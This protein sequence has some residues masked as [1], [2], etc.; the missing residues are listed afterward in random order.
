MSLDSLMLSPSLKASLNEAA[1]RY[2]RDVAGAA[3]YLAGRGLDEAAAR[4]HHLGFVAEPVVGHERFEGMLAIPYMTPL[5]CVAM[6]FRRIDGEDPKYDSPSGQKA[7]LY[8][9]QTLGEGGPVALICEGELDAVAAEAHLG[10]PA[11]GSPGTTWLDHWSRC[12]G[13]FDRVVVVAD[14]D[15][16]DDGSDPGLKHAQKVR[17]SIEGADLVTPPAGLDLTDWINV[18]GVEAVRGGLGLC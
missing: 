16:K 1:A 17:K 4:S 6:K 10:V 2:S 13:D 12:F 18:H 3:S 14:H 5:G 8:N 15:A 7:R 9:A 11:V